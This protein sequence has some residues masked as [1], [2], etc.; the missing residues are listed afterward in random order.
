MIKKIIINKLGRFKNF[1]FDGVNNFQ[2][3][4]VL[5]GWNYSGKTTLS[6]GFMPFDTKTIPEHY[7]NGFDIIFEKEDGI[8]LNPN[9]EF[10]RNRLQV[11]VFNSDYV[12][13]NL[14]FKENGASNILVLADNAQEIMTKIEQLSNEIKSRLSMISKFKDQQKDNKNYLEERR[15]EE[16]R[17]IKTSLHCTFTASTFLK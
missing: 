9:I 6:R 13:T 5:Y 12:E 17:K 7:E 10:D 11:K 2:R 16:A 14:F 4:N 15:S 1:N 8:K 3:F